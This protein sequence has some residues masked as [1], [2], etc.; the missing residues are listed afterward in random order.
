MDIF[1][2]P[3]PLSVRRGGDL[4]G[5]QGGLH[6]R[7]VP[8]DHRPE[9]DGGRGSGDGAT[10]LLHAQTE[11]G[12][13][14]GRRLTFRVKG[15]QKVRLAIHFSADYRSAS[16]FRGGRSPYLWACVIP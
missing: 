10:A 8:D 3:G 1:S 4:R 16:R 7:R 15:K 13:V 5:L 11:V 2:T 14:R 9:D 12:S 6:A